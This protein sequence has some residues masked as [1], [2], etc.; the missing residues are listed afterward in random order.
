M[1]LAVVTNPGGRR[2]RLFADAV[3]AAGLPPA[4]EIPWRR[5]AAGETPGIPRGALVR[6]DSP[7]GDAEV[8]RLLRGDAEPAEHGEIRSGEAWYAGFTKALERLGGTLLNDPAELAV[9][10]DKRR[11][12][13]VLTSA[14]VPVPEA[15]PPLSGYA[16]LRGEMWGA[17]WSR[18]FIKP[19]HG[20]SASGVIAFEQAGRRLVATTSVEVSGGRLYN[21]LTVRRYTDEATVRYIVDRLGPL[22]VERWYPKAGLGGRTVDLRVVVIGGEPTHVVV[23][24]SRHPMT[25]LHL[26][27]QR[28]DVAAV[29]RAAGEEQWAAAME[30]CARAAAQFPGCLQVGVDLMF[31]SNWRRHAV[32]EVNAFGDLLPGLL[33]EHGRDTYA[34]QVHRLVARC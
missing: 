18:V 16:D 22:H 2:A 14:G 25:N 28:G 31:A 15:A 33:N 3:R 4:V 1:R 19:P 32:A 29:R 30:T 6:I 9:L 34:E 5:L 13:A 10:F 24:A 27:A 7:D 8:D 17:G 12:H 11:C 26:G 21:S 23:R 20:S